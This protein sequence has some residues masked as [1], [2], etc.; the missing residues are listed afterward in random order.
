MFRKNE[1]RKY[2]LIDLRKKMGNIRDAYA[3]AMVGIDKDVTRNLI[4]YFNQEGKIGEVIDID[5][6]LEGRIYLESI[7]NG[8]FWYADKLR[9]NLIGYDEEKEKNLYKI[10]VLGTHGNQHKTY[11]WDVDTSILIPEL[12]YEIQNKL[13]ADIRKFDRPR[14]FKRR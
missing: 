14:K 8:E 3:R 7:G 5:T 2:V 9:I 13:R 1:D 11:I 12:K 10:E 4:N 6:G